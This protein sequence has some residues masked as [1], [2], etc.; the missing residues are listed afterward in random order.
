MASIERYI[1]LSYQDK[2]YEFHNY[3]ESDD[4]AIFDAINK[5]EAQ[6][7]KM[8]GGL[9]KYFKAHPENIIVKFWG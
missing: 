5:L 6:L 3:K 9:I 7:N 8:R 4:K 2:N 1:L